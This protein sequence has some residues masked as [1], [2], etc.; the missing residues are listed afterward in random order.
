MKYE[1]AVMCHIGHI[2]K[3]NEDN[4]YLNGQIR[5]DTDTAVCAFCTQGTAKTA[6]FAVAD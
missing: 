2:R 5:R 1:A 3:N 4:F 6:L